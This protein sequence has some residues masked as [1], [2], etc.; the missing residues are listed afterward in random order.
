M[1]MPAMFPI[2][3]MLSGR[4]WIRLATVADETSLK[5]W[6]V[7]LTFKPGAIIHSNGQVAVAGDTLGMFGN[8]VTVMQQ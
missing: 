1:T 8:Q 5:R 4:E 7:T 6:W 3:D 2:D